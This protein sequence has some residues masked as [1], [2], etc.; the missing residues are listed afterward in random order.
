MMK[1]VCNNHFEM[2]ILGLTERMCNIDTVG[3]NE[4]YATKQSSIN[5]NGTCTNNGSND[6]FGCGSV[7]EK[8]NNIKNN[9]DGPLNNR[10]STQ[11]EIRGWS[12]HASA[13][14][15]FKIADDELNTV[16]LSNSKYGGVKFCKEKFL[17]GVS[18]LL[19]HSL[20]HF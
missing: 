2:K 19:C 4:F 7:N 14:T 10:L 12:F 18:I 8:N 5:G 1:I 15:K 20:F 3:E 17:W 13:N 6:I 9:C 11:T 16:T